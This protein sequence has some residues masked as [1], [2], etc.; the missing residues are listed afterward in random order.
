MH[1]TTPWPVIWSRSLR[2][3][4]ASRRNAIVAAGVL[5]ERRAER[6][7]VE[8]MLADMQQYEGSGRTA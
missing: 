6:H 5:R 7:E 1:E 2:S 3:S 8:R 4:A